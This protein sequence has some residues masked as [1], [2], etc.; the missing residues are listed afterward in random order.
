MKSVELARSDLE[1]EVKRLQETIEGKDKSFAEE[2]RRLEIVHRDEMEQQRKEMSENYR[3]Q[4]TKLQR[5]N[6]ELTQ[7][8]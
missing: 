3:K 4:E 2:K 7:V 5:Q 6:S 8:R 1:E